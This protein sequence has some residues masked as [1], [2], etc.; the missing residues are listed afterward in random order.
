MIGLAV[1]PSQVIDTVDLFRAPGPRARKLSLRFLS[2]ALLGAS[3][4]GGEHDSVEDAVAALAL[5]SKWRELKRE[6]TLERTIKE[7]YVRGA[8]TGWDPVA[9]GG[10]GGGAAAA[11]LELAEGLRL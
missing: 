8:A 6:G 3:I 9:V 10:G 2:A 7:L 1:P 4:Q 5:F 11:A